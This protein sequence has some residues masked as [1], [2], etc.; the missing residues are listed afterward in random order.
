M[1]LRKR[2]AFEHLIAE[3]SARLINCPPVETKARLERALAEFGRTI[4]ADR[5]YIVLRENP[6]RVYSWSEDN[7]P[8]PPDGRRGL[9][10]CRASSSRSG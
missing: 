9:S 4:E 3:Q 7:A 6:I 2:A 8:F 1:A 5:V 10:R